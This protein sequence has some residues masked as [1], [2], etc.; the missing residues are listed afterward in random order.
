MNNRKVT[1]NSYGQAISTNYTNGGKY[2]M[3]RFFTLACLCPM[4]LGWAPSL[5]QDHRPT[6][7][8][9]DSWQCDYCKMLF[10]NKA[11][12]A[13]VEFIGDSTLVFDATECLAGYLISTRIPDNRIRKIWS[14]DYCRPAELIDGKLAAYLQSDKLLSPMGVNI[15]AVASDRQ[16][17]SLLARLGGHKLDWY[18][19]LRLVKSKWYPDMQQQEGT[20]NVS[21]T[22]KKATPKTKK[23]SK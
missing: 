11:Y 22:E 18:G 20:R 12:G 9:Y 21:G 16:A 13:E 17:D 2:K 19:V 3:I 7:V 4:L 10:E 8:V 23:R 5:A 6:N 1:N 15:A 14:I